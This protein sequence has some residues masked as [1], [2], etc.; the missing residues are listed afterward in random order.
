M[1][2]VGSSM[3]DPVVA[4]AEDDPG[5]I[6]VLDSDAPPAIDGEDG[7]SQNTGKT[8]V[9]EAAYEA[10]AR[11]MAFDSSRLDDSKPATT[12]PPPPEE[13]SAAPAFPPPEKPLQIE[14]A[15]PLATTLPPQPS[16]FTPS[17]PEPTVE[18]TN[19][20]ASPRLRSMLVGV[21]VF[22][23]VVVVVLVFVNFSRR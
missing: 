19:E 7:Y 3:Y 1:Q 4:K 13:A 6:A 11:T 20:E 21:V 14:S 2:H 10:L 23:V 22:L 5:R 18:P 17:P 15:T 8:T 16:E 12:K 9:G